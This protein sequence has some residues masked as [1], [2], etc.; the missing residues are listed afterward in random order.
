LPPP[1]FLYDQLSIARVKG[2]SVQ[3][4]DVSLYL[5]L[6]LTPCR[7]LLLIVMLVDE[8]DL[9]TELIT[10]LIHASTLSTNNAGNELLANLELGR[11]VQLDMLVNEQ[12][13][14]RQDRHT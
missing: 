8:V 9:D 3:L 5:D 14:S 11:L 4:Y 1:R 7:C 13:R 10:D 12:C 2:Y 6:D